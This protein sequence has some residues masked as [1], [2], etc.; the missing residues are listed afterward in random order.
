[1]NKKVLIALI[2]LSS[3]AKANDFKEVQ[4]LALKNGFKPS[5]QVIQAVV[6]AARWYG[7]NPLDLASIGL[8][9]TGLGKYTSTNTNSNG[10]QD[11]G[12]FQ[13][14]TINKSK[15][16][17]FDLNTIEG[18]A[19]CAAKLL[20]NIKKHYAPKDPEWTAI[21]HSKTKKYKKVY[22]A[23]ITKVLAMNT[24]K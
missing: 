1:M 4:D 13:I 18:S 16:I 24:D 11:T 10:T 12:I 14:N 7:L 2:L 9:E 5:K 23:K 21:Y 8:I 6:K 17:K 3:Q 15:C 19:F 20:A 22:F